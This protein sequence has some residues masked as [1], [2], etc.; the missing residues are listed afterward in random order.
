M[1]LDVN[2]ALERKNTSK[3]SKWY[4]SIILI[5]FL[6]A[7]FF[8]AFNGKHNKLPFGT[9]TAIPPPMDTSKPKIEQKSQSGNN[10]NAGG[11]VQQAGHDNIKAGRDAII[12][13]IYSDTTKSKKSPKIQPKAEIK[14]QNKNG[15]NQVN[16]NPGVNLGNIGGSNN[17]VNNN[18]GIQ[19]RLLQEHDID[20][21]FLQF[22]N[23]ATRI[24]FT[25]YNSQD[26]EMQNVRNQV[27]N[28]LKEH[29]YGNIEDYISHRLGHSLPEG[30]ISLELDKDSSVIFIIYPSR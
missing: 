20:S 8:L 19:P 18:F 21:F 26:A 14:Q 15:N 11:D 27:I 10:V 22:P 9:E 7:F 6:A 25:F 12:T 16:Q 17:T 29:G 2:R 1:K 4:I 5:A 3:F 30:D 28:I 24:K 13:N 23:K